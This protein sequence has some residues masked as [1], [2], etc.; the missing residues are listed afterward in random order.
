MRQ[1]ET[2]RQNKRQHEYK[3]TQH[4]TTEM[5]HD[6]T[7]HDT[8]ATRHNMSKTQDNKSTKQHKIYFDLFILLL[9]TQSLVY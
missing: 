6:T 5:Q 4:E 7:G 1:Q 2:T 3:T 9:Y 8:S